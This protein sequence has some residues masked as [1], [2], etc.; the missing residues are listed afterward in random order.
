MFLFFLPAAISF[1]FSPAF[2]LGNISFLIN[3]IIYHAGALREIVADERAVIKMRKLKKKG[4]YREDSNGVI[5]LDD[6][7]DDDDDEGDCYGDDDDEEV[8][9]KEDTD[10]S[11]TDMS[12]R[13]GGQG[14][15]RVLPSS[16]NSSSSSSSF[17]GKESELSK[18]QQ[19]A[20]PP[21]M[22][23]QM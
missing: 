23:A 16:F 20:E 5:N 3:Y 2:L 9:S 12:D 11:A 1:T 18:Q 7:D 19:S 17:S 6:D 8:T 21:D 15:K 14:S 10:C 4:S 13:Y 22:L